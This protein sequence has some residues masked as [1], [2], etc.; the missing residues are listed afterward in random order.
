MGCLWQSPDSG[1]T[2]LVDG[3][4]EHGHDARRNQGV[5]P[6]H[7]A[8]ARV[9]QPGNAGWARDVSVSL[10][11]VG[12][13]RV[14]AGDRA[15][16]LQAYE[17]GLGI[18]RRLAAADPGNVEW[19]RDVCVSLF[20]LGLIQEIGGERSVTAALYREA[21][22]RNQ[23]LVAIDPGNAKWANDAAELQARLAA[24]QGE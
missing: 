22:E 10:N 17:E 9:H 13:V 19:A 2:A 12:D 11:K 24:V 15:G 7:P 1:A 20:R 8:N 23:R 5:E 21:A 18:R 4:D 6:N 3:R 16:A 14:A